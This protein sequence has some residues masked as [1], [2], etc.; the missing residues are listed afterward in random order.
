MSW[1][2][3]IEAVGSLLF[4]GPKSIEECP[5]YLEEFTG[6]ATPFPETLMFQGRHDTSPL[7]GAQ[8]DGSDADVRLFRE[9]ADQFPSMGNVDSLVRALCFMAMILRRRSSLA[10]S[11]VF[12]SYSLAD[13][14]SLVLFPNL[15]FQLFYS[16]VA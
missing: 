15:P 8:Q 9:G 10:V 3:I 1:G 2:V 11:G 5:V 13:Q 12:P 7:E 16:A 4:S 14:G 6:L